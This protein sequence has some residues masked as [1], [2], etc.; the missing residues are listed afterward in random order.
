MFW[1]RHVPTGLTI[2]ARA[3]AFRW[4]EIVVIGG[5]KLH[6]G[7]PLLEIV[8]ASDIARFGF[9]LVE[10]REKQ[11]HENGDDRDG[12]EQFDEAETGRS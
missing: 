5:V 11:A 3:G 9:R 12:Y 7:A 10:R 2:D 8:Q 1:E 4:Q 6:G